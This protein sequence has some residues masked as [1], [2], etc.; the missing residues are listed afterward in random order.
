MSLFPAYLHVVSS[1]QID[2]KVGKE[3]SLGTVDGVAEEAIVGFATGFS[4]AV[5]DGDDDDDDD[6]I[7]EYEKTKRRELYQAYMKFEKKHGDR[8]RIENVIIN[9]R[10][11]SYQKAIDTDPYD[12]DSW[13]EWAK[14][15]QDHYTST[16]TASSSSSSST[17]TATTTTGTPDAVREVYERAVAQ[18]PPTTDQKITGG[19]TFICG[20]TTR[21][22]R[23]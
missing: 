5:R 14:L 1:E 22:S 3:F 11:Q 16:S 20:S 18:V 7:T 8:E 4:K 19:G 17:T 13:F 6:E 15:E 9:N 10:R 12:N 21:C 2:E 23:K